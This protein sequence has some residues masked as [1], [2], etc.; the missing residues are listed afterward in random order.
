MS[1]HETIDERMET[2]DD[3]QRRASEL[4]TLYEVARA[5]L[6]ARNPN[7]V[8]A[9]IVL[10][11]MGALG[12]RSGAMFVADA[13][14][15]Y[16]LL[17]AEDGYTPPV[18]TRALYAAAPNRKALWLVPG[19]SHGEVSNLHDAEWARRIGEFLRETIGTP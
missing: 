1:A 4:A 14:G 3:S 18:E 7:Q 15:R 16:E 12:V 11:G 6:G 10:A 17:C 5:L 9:R 2:R 13:R 19:L 8:A